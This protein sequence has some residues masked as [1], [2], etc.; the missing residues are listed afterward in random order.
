MMVTTTPRNTAQ[1]MPTPN[2]LPGPVRPLWLISFVV[3]LALV[4]LGIMKFGRNSE[5]RMLRR[6]VPVGA[7]ALLLVAVG[8]MSGCNGGFPRVVNI[9]GTP[10]GTYPITVTGT[11]GTDQHSTIVTLTVQ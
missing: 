4:S 3:M 6:L 8:A 11:S 7:L 2:N 1:V 10:A 9:V 5:L